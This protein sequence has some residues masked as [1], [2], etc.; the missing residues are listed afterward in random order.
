[1]AK[2]VISEAY[3]FNKDTKIITV[4]G[5]V[6]RREQLILILNVRTN[7]VLFNF[8]DTSTTFNAYT[9][10]GTPNAE[11]TTITLGS[12]VDTSSMTNN[13]PLSIIVDETNETF[14][15]AETYMDPVQKMRVSTPQSLIDTDFE[16]GT[17]PTKWETI[18]LLNNRPSA[19]FDITNP[20]VPITSIT[21]TGTGSRVVTVISGNTSVSNPF[22]LLLPVFIQE[23]T[24]PDANGWFLP[25]TVGGSQGAW[26]FTYNANVGITPSSSI[27]DTTKTYMW[28]GAFF[29]GA[30]ITVNNSSGL[31]FTNSGTVVTCTTVFAHGL[32]IGDGIFVVGTTATGAPP[33]GN[34]FVKTTPTTNTFTFDV[35]NA[36]SGA[37]ITAANGGATTL[38]ARSL[39]FSQHRPFDGGVNFTAGTPFHG[40]Q[41]IRQTRRYFRYQSGKGIQFS[42]GSNFCPLLF[43]DSVTNGGSGQ[44]VTVTTKYPHYLGTGATIVVSGCN[45]SA[46]NGTFTIASTPSSTTLTYSCAPNTPTTAPALGWPI[47]IGAKNWYGAAIRVGMFD[48][49][50]G[51][52]F[53][54]DGTTIYAV[55][56]R[57]TDQLSGTIT[58]LANGSVIA[59]GIGTR[60]ARELIPGDSIVIRGM[61]YTAQ[62]IQSD[63]VMTIYPEYRGSSIA[64]PSQVVVSKTVNTRYPQSSW[65]IDRANGTGISGFNLDITKMQMWYI[66]YAWYGAGAVRFGIKNQRGEVYYCHR[67]ANANQRTEAYMRSGNLPARYEVNTNWPY[68]AL[69]S[70]LNSGDTGMTVTSNVGFP[71]SGVLMV[72]ACGTTSGGISGVIEFIR[73]TGKS[74]TTVFTGLTRGVTD[75]TGP[76]GLTGGGGSVATTFTVSNP[77]TSPTQVS[78][79]S[80]Q[81]GVTIG[82]WGSSVTMDGRYDDDKSIQFNFGM[83]TPVT[84]A[85]AQQRYPIMSIRLGPSVDNGITGTL[86]QREI[87]NR[88]QLQ[89]AG[90]GV[91]PTTSGVKVELIFNGRV[92]GGTFAALGGSSLAQAVL[93]ANTTSISGGELIYTFFAPAGGVSTQDLSKIR[94]IGNSILG[95]GNTLNV[96]NT[97]NNKYPDG[98]DIITL[99]VTPLS[100]NASVVARINWTEAQA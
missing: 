53:E 15:P 26:T 86:G 65:N 3:T 80:P 8:S 83:N 36:P 82:H 43:V 42:T 25:Q 9:S 61:T 59:T 60:W 99:C 75:L 96:P 46:Y 71:D 84:Y 70:T 81:A 91:Y 2:R 92:N 31:A 7:T 30:G 20:I 29:T 67:I 57:S 56:R 44:T 79:Y 45:D 93:H 4:L 89:P 78:L 73:Y 28:I 55:A 48:S 88:M 18:A 50:N 72:S 87:I 13:D 90:I 38:F 24:N 27:F 40:N 69:A 21:P 76:A 74:G 58:T 33:N 68:T 100:A 66:D 17:Q 23:T 35:I 6:I 12:G 98:P 63:T 51:F 85:N 39:G 94:D 77:N 1:M 11:T 14:Q 62:A 95:G 41:L 47:N 32:S 10:D 37:N 22:G 16:Y 19:F 54:Y 49:Q 34:W 97:D 52:Y 64:A 5:K